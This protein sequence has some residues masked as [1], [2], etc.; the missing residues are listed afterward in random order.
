[1]HSRA[2]ICVAAIIAALT[3]PAGAIAQTADP[4]DVKRLIE[5]EKRHPNMISGVE[6]RARRRNVISPVEVRA[7]RNCLRARR[8]ADPDI[9]PPKLVDTFPANG[10]VVRPGFL[11]LR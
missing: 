10:A 7:R 9:P 5:E 6:V 1:M 3:G 2:L 8:P 4:S 11:V